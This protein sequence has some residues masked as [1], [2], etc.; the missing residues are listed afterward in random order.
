MLIVSNKPIVL[1]VTTVSVIM[2]NVIYA[3]NDL[4]LGSHSGCHYAECRA[5]SQY[6]ECHYDKCHYAQCHYAQCHYTKC[7][8]AECHGTIDPI[9]KILKRQSFLL[10]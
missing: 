2:L 7:H 10:L 3:G 4:C 8:Y 9:M 1:C 6:A 5:E